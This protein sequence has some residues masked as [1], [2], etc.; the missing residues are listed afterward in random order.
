MQG[1]LPDMHG[2]A[3][4]TDRLILVIRIWQNRRLRFPRAQKGMASGYH[5]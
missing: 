5:N 4:G 3:Q 2:P 1:V